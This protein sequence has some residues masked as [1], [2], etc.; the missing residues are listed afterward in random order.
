VENPVRRFNQ[1]IDM[2]FE[3][4]LEKGK[5]I[6]RYKRFL[7][8][9]EMQDGR[10]LTLHCP[11][12]GSMR[13]CAEAGSSVWFS[14]SGNLKRKYLYTWELVAVSQDWLACINTQ[15]ANG[16]VSEA[17]REGRIKPLQGYDRILP[18][19]R[20]GIE[21]SRIDLLLQ[22]AA[23][24]CYIEVK[25]VTLLERD[26]LGLFPDARTERGCKHL[27]ELVKV[28]AEGQR[29]VLFFCVAHNGIER[30]S[31]AWA[32][33]PVYAETLLWAHSQGVEVLAYGAH[34][35]PQQIRLERQLEV[36]LWQH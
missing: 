26:N 23:A 4:P 6:R 32:I 21:N 16:L 24:D 17:I 14:N 35:S 8:D 3:P 5:L 30:V 1:E 18:E 33:D 25:N 11:N 22:G 15:R 9:I 27:R 31:P 12:T 28:A 20:Y 7:A 36:I 2:Q 10:T 34:I 19:V 13:N 29:A